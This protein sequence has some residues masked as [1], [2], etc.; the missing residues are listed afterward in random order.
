VFVATAGTFDF[1]HVHVGDNYRALAAAYVR[2]QLH[3]LERPDPRLA[4]LDN[5]YDLDQRRDIPSRWDN[6]Y[7]EGGTSCISRR[8]RH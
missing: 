3:L 1:R 5:P 8:C 6:T 2:G 7:Y 4:A